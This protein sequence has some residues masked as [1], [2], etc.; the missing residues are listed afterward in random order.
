M[1]KLLPKLIFPLIR[2][3]NEIVQSKLVDFLSKPENDMNLSHNTPSSISKF[4]NKLNIDIYF[5]C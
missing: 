3:R 5:R 1:M 2:P 4:Q